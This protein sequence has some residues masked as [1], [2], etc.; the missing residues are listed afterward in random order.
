M[1]SG[2]GGFDLALNRQGHECIGYS[3]IN[4]YSIEIYKK[5]FGEEVKNYGDATK[6]KADELPDFDMLCGG[7]P[8]Q[9]FSIAGKR[10]GFEDTR[11]T[12]FFD[13][14]RIIKAKRPSYVLLE[15]VKGLLNHDKGETFRVIIQTLSELGYDVQWMVL[16]SK[17]F[18]VPQNRERVFIIGSLGGTSRPEILPISECIGET[19]EL[20]YAQKSDREIARVYSPEGVAPTL[21]LKTSGWQEPKI[22]V[23]GKINSSQDGIIHNTQGLSQCLS[24]GHGNQPKIITHSLFPRSS[25]TNKGGTGHLSKDDGTAY[26][27]DSGNCQAIAIAVLTPDREKKRQNGWQEPKIQVAIKAEFQ[28]TA[29]DCDGISPT[30]RDGHGD[31][32]RIQVH[33]LFPRSSTT[34]KGGIG[35]LQKEDGTSYCLDEGCSQAIIL[36][37][38]NKKIHTDRTPTL[39]EPHHNSIR[40]QEPN[41]KI[42]KL[43]PIECERLQGFPD[44]WTEG[45]SDTR[46]YNQLGNAVTTNVIQ[47]I[48][49][50]MFKQ[51]GGLA[52]NEE[53]HNGIPPNNKLLGILPTIL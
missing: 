8:C 21:H 11:G 32:V 20:V 41:L 15:N 45:V 44:G 27:L 29:Y 17:F 23:E 34:K 12:L 48:I 37:C 5:N 1:F 13:V 25:K 7:F 31:V 22:M 42:R 47:A 24:A 33:S 53:S 28:K 49:K 16:N 40:L 39:T 36:D 9:A 30:I 46:R 18:G 38:Y 4:K 3:E 51:E 6:I 43:T 26:C 2:I 14:A 52:V 19:K 35:H 50:K 10:R